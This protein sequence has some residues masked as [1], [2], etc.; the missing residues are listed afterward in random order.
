[1]DL[2]KLGNK[3]DD[4]TL[5]L[6]PLY[7]A[8]PFIGPKIAGKP[9]EILIARKGN[10]LIL[11]DAWDEGKYILLTDGSKYRKKGDFKLK[12]YGEITLLFANDYTIKNKLGKE[13][14]ETLLELGDVAFGKTAVYEISRVDES[15]I[16]DRLV[17]KIWYSGTEKWRLPITPSAFLV[18]A[19]VGIVCMLMMFVFLTNMPAIIGTIHAQAVSKPPVEFINAT[20]NA[21]VK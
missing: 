7:Y 3:T 4:I 10:P 1:M 18:L 11:R 12:S 16:I 20:I 19:V 13:K 9:K 8:I 15:K 14:D 5:M 17:E 2:N 6:K 21:T